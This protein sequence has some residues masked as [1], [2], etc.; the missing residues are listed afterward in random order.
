[1]ETEIK[2]YS[3]ERLIPLAVELGQPKFRA[4]QLA[5]WL[6]GH[7]VDSYN[8]MGNLPKSFREKLE[9]EHPLFVPTVANRQFS[10]DG[11]RKYVLEFHDGA[12]VETVAMPSENETGHKKMSVCVS[13][14]VGCSM[15]CSFCATGKEG[16]SRNLLPGEI[17]DQ[18][19]VAETDTG[20]S[21]TSLVTMGQGEPFL[22][23]G[24]VIDALR[25]ANHPKLLGIGA[26]HITLSTC[27][28][29]KGINLLSREPEQFTLAVSLHSAIQE[30]RDK[31]MPKMKNE[32]LSALKESLLTYGERTNR[33][34]SFEYILLAGITDDDASLRALISYCKGLLC[35]VNLLPVN[36]IEKSPFHPSSSSVTKKWI[37]ELEA[38]HIPVTLRNSRGSDISG[39]CGQLKNSLS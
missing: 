33:R 39:A 16:F 4:D 1:M 13:T 23:Y 22:N 32:S 8:K 9:A 2:A 24:N 35:H 10:Q 38:V 34:V 28:I 30:T 21:A 29:I 20:I 14:Q 6:Y 11:T 12:Q 19:K 17:V 7:S 25:F 31:L 15:G 26:R 36:K 37:T 5:N 3:Y 27:G 18:I